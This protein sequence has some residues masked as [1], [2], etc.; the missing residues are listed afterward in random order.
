MDAFLDIIGRNINTLPV[1]GF[2]A[3]GTDVLVLVGVAFGK[4]V[5]AGVGVAAGTVPDL[6]KV[7]DQTGAVFPLK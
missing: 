7:C 6:A 1:G 2:F 3:V 4:D 5:R